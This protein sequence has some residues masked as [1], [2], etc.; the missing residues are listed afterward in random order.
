MILTNI[1]LMK[2]KNIEISVIYMFDNIDF[3]AIDNLILENWFF[4]TCISSSNNFLGKKI[5]II[6]VF[7]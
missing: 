7:R 3:S 6:T 4:D 1:P 5:I 2:A